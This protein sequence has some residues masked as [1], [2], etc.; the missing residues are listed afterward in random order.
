MSPLDAR[1][2][3]T[4][5]AD[6]RAILLSGSARTLCL[7]DDA[8]PRNIIAT[9]PE[10]SDTMDAARAAAAYEKNSRKYATV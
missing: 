5:V 7:V 1:F 6:D 2:L 9:L 4:G 3:D 8:V 10:G